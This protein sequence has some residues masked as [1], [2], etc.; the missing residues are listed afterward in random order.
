MTFVPENA[1][2]VLYEP[3][4]FTWLATVLTT[5]NGLIIISTYKSSELTQAVSPVTSSVTL[6]SLYVIVP[7][8]FVG[9][10]IS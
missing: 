2:T 6:S 9:T 3:L 5:G 1:T 10:V 7:G 8:L 4:H